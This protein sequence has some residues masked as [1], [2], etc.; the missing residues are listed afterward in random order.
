VDCSTVIFHCIRVLS[1]NMFDRVLQEDRIV[2]C[3]QES[4]GDSV[5]RK[6]RT[7]DATVT[8]APP[9]KSRLLEKTSISPKN[10][11]S[12]TASA[13]YDFEE[14]LVSRMSELEVSR[15]FVVGI[16]HCSTSIVAP[17]VLRSL[18]SATADWISYL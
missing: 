1:V 2:C 5:K 11:T 3:G 10:T 9:A 17:A 4:S 7:S 16:C 12:L 14:P 6:K 8:T 18:L 15:G 13:S